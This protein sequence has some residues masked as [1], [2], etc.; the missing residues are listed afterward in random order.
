MSTEHLLELIFTLDIVFKVGISIIC[1]VCNLSNGNFSVIP[2]RITFSVIQN[3]ARTIIVW[4]DASKL[5]RC[6]NLRI[7]FN[8]K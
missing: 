5:I 4:I 6:I 3:K 8:W 7:K 1:D 2:E